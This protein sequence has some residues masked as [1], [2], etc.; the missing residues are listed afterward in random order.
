MDMNYDFSYEMLEGMGAAMSTGELAYNVMMFV[1]AIVGYILRSISLYSIASRRGITNAWLS[2]IP[3]AW[4]WVLGSISDQFRYVTKAQV[5]A[6][7]ITLLVLK[8]ISVVL[9]IA[10]FVLMIQSFMNIMELGLDI[11]EEEAMAEGMTLLLKV[12]GVGL[13]AVVVAL[14][15]TIIYYIALYDLYVSTNPGN[16]G[17]FLVLSIFFSATAP[18]MMF[19]DRKKD[20]GMPPRC[21]VPQEPVSYMSAVPAQEPWENVTEE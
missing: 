11:T 17:L 14:A 15:M 12:G 18:F 20:G 7:R 9:V 1:L 21:D 13:L 10:M 3:V 4:I 19:F 6:K 5:K 2:W 8:L 16:A